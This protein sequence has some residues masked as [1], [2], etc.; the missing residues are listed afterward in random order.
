MSY[1]TYS[2]VIF[3][4]SAFSRG[5]ALFYEGYKNE[6]HMKVTLKKLKDL[7]QQERLLRYIHIQDSI[8]QQL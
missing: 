7:I 1:L 8:L 2:Y 5:K 3:S 4:H 6:E